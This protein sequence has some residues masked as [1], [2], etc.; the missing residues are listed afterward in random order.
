MKKINKFATWVLILGLVF[1][2]S[3]DNA[4]IAESNSVVFSDLSKN[5]WA[6][7]AVYEMVRQGVINGFGDGTFRPNDAVQVDQ[8]IKMLI[9]VLSEDQADGTRWWKDEFLNRTD[10]F[11]E[12]MIYE[13]SP[14]FEFKPAKNGYWA[15]PFIEQAQNMSIVNKYGPWGDK[16]DSPLV[17]KHV[18][19][20]L[21]STI[22]L[23]EE[24]EETNYAE[25]ARTQIKDIQTLKE[26]RDIYSVTN[27][28][29]K[30]L[31]KGY[32]DGRFGVDR[33]VTRAEAVV[34]LNRI[35]DKSQRDSYQPNLSPYPHAEVPT[36]NGET[37]MV[38]FPDWHMKKAYDVMIENREK[39]KGITYHA[40]RDVSMIY[41]KDQD[42][43]DQEVQR[44]E[45][46][47]GMFKAPYMDVQ[48]RF[49][50]GPNNYSLSINTEDDGW[51]RHKEAMT[52]F[53]KQIFGSDTDIFIQK[54]EKTVEQKKQG[55]L[56][57]DVT[58]TLNN[59]LVRFANSGFENYVYIY[60]KKAN[61]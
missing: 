46:V 42:Q 23:I 6:H 37:K 61:S 48:L 27:V 38:V 10:A 21:M 19:E 16:F 15:K 41:Y 54:L 52:P 53:F 1:S 49:G 18:A 33:I 7:D 25:L 34:I 2:F 55:T 31:M 17:R 9:L 40:K 22:E 39:S 58:I 14:G 11:T 51:Y 50:T 43:H 30:G 32:P 45:Y 13:G 44:S 12:H 36:R 20:I 59:R 28:Y 60:F 24:P 56:S 57:E 29:I 35:L 5:H 47:N 4:S 8:F 3:L 26:S